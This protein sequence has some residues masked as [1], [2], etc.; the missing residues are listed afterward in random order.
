MAVVA[1]V[2]VPALKVTVHRV[3][4]PEPVDALTTAVPVGIPVC[5][6]VTVTEKVAAS[7]L[8]KTTE[9]GRTETAVALDAW[10]TVITAGTVAVDGEKLRV[11]RVGGGH[12]MGAG[13]ELDTR[14]RRAGVGGQGHRTQ[15]GGAHGEGDRA[16]WRAD[17]LRGDRGSEHRGREVAVGDRGW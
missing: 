3:T 12:T 11:T 17:E 9:A 6:G 13:R 10:E 4:V 7:S 14:R 5:C 2:P 1:Q 15:G 16:G 8:P